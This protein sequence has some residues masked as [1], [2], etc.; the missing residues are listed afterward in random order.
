MNSNLVLIKYIEDHGFKTCGFKAGKKGFDIAVMDEYTK[1]GKT[2]TEIVYVESTIETVKT[3][4][5]Y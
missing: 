1:D 5:G 3:W 4:L 2:Y